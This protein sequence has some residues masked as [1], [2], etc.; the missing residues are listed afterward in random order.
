MDLGNTPISTWLRNN[1]MC[2]FFGKIVCCSDVFTVTEN[3]AI[4]LAWYP[5]LFLFCAWDWYRKANKRT[6]K[7]KTAAPQSLDRCVQPWHTIE[8]EAKTKPISKA[9]LPAESQVNYL[10]QIVSLESLC[11]STH[12]PNKHYTAVKNRIQ[13]HPLCIIL[14][15]T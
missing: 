3:F 1:A 8:L 7:Q 5:S 10:C 15:H 6:N 14:K 11:E 9:E 13:G 12:E 4:I 2:W